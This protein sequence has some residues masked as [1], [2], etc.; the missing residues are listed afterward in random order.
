MRCN[1]LLAF[2]QRRVHVL[3]QI[4]Y[5]FIHENYFLPVPATP[6]LNYFRS[7]QYLCRCL[8]RISQSHISVAVSF[9]N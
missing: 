4:M 3:K 6:A 7:S 1:I 8:C 5:Y 2:Y 9:S